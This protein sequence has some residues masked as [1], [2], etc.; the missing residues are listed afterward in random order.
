SGTL[1][2]SG[3]ASDNVAVSSV[4]VSVDGGSFSNATGTTSWTFSLNTASLSNATHSLVAKA[5]DSSGNT[6][7]TTASSITVSNLGGPTVTINWTD[8]HQRIDGFGASSA[9]TGD[10]ITTAQADLFWTTTSGVGLSLLRMRIQSN[11]TYPELATLQKAQDRG[12]KIWG[13]PWS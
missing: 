5:T 9:F 6:A 12:V 1:T 8:V 11:G 3:T 4:Q 2:V 13:T 10:G 7:T